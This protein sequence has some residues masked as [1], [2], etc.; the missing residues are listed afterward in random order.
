MEALWNNFTII[1]ETKLAYSQFR[2]YVNIRLFGKGCIRQV[3]VILL[4]AGL[5]RFLDYF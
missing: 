1:Y 4:S 3:D 2:R 5:W